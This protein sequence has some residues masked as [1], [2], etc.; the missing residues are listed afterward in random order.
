KG[1]SF[2]D[3]HQLDMTFIQADALSQNVSQYIHREQHAVALHACGDLHVRLIEIAAKQKIQ[4][5]TISPCCYHLT[6]DDIYQPLSKEARQGQL[7]LSKQELRIPLQKTVTGGARVRRHRQLE[8]SY[9]LALAKLIQH[10]TGE[11]AY[12]PIPS[13][14]KSKLADGFQAFCEW[15]IAQKNLNLDLSLVEDFDAWQALGETM[16]WQM[17]ALGLVQGLYKRAI[18]TWL[19]LDKALFLQ[20]EGYDVTLGQ[21]CSQ[22]VTPRNLYLQAKRID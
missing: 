3:K 5:L 8:M 22:E 7:T 18:E 10:L 19:L 13:I 14:Q 9:R 2:A 17:E 21:F 15:A 6:Q 11:K 16:F 4:A 12:V 1:Q 20:S